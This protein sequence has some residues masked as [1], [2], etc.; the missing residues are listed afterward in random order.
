M[1]RWPGVSCLENCSH[2]RLLHPFRFERD[3]A[4]DRDAC[5]VDDATAQ[6]S[7][8]VWHPQQQSAAE[9]H[10]QEQSD[11]YKECFRGLGRRNTL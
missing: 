6:P 5:E 1:V 11:V 4:S 7:V 8:D 10:T 9:Q 2:N 3:A